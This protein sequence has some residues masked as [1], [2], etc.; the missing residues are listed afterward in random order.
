MDKQ[1]AWSIWR[2]VYGRPGLFRCTNERPQIP[3]KIGRGSALRT[4][5]PGD[6]SEAL[7][8]RGPLLLDLQFLPLLPQNRLAAQLDLV[9]FERQDFHQNLVALLQLVPHLFN[10]VLGDFAD[11]QQAEI[12]RAHV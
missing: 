3:A 6:A 9:A 7:R 11:M 8:S 12:G 1:S 10:A 4:S 2:V 5:R